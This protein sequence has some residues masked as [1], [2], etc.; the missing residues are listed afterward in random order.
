MPTQV[1]TCKLIAI[2]VCFAFLFVTLFVTQTARAQTAASQEPI[3]SLESFV[4]AGDDVAGRLIDIN[5]T[6]TTIDP[7]WNFGF[8]QDGEHA[9]FV[10]KID[11]KKFTFADR[12]RIQGVAGKGDLKAI[13]KVTEITF[14]EK[15]IAPNPIEVDV[16]NLD[17]GD[18]DASYV[19]TEGTV[20]QVVC[21]MGQTL[22]YC[23]NNGVEFHACLH[24][25]QPMDE[26]WKRV[27]AKIEISGVLGV[28]IEP[29][30]ERSEHAIGKRDIECF[31]IWAMQDFEVLEGGRKDPLPTS[32]DPESSAG[33]FLLGGQITSLLRASFTMTDSEQA[34]LMK[35]KDFHAFGESNI[36]RV[37]GSRTPSSGQQALVVEVLFS[38]PIPNPIKFEAIEQDSDLWSLVRVTGHPEKIRRKNDRVCFDIRSGVKKAI[39]ELQ[40]QATTSVELLRSARLVDVRGIVSEIDEEGVCKVVVSDSNQVL[41][42]EPK[43]SIWKYVAAVLFPLT[44]LI[45]IGFM[46]VKAQRNRADSLAESIN[47]M[48]TR[49]VSTYEAIS[50]GLLAVDV[51][52]RVLT[53]NSEFCR[54]IG[55]NL[56]PGEKFTASTSQDFLGQMKNR[57]AVEK[58]IFGR[59]TDSKKVCRMEIE[60]VRPEPG[61]FDLEVSD[62][63]SDKQARIGRLFLLRDRTKERQLQAELIH[64]NKI[65]AVGQL[66]GGIAHDFN[67]ILTA[68]TANLSLLDLEAEDD[69]RATVVSAAESA[70]NRGTEMVRR[71]LTYSGKTKLRPESQSINSVIRELH[72]FTKATFDSRYEFSF[73]LDVS[74]PLVRVDAGAIEQVILNL[75]LNARDSMPNG[76]KILTV[77]RCDTGA[78]ESVVRIWVVDDGPGVPKHIQ[79][80]IFEPF[81]TTKAGQAGTGLGLSTSKR[82][83][84]ELN[85]TLEYK[86]SSKPG[87]RFVIALPTSTEAQVVEESKEPIPNCALSGSKTI[88]VVDDEDAIRKIY[89]LILEPHEIQV[90]TAVN[91]QAALAIL[92]QEHE[93]IDLVLLD[94]TMPGMSGLDVLEIVSKKYSKIP[95][96]LCSGYLAGI[97]GE[98]DDCVLKLPKPFSAEQLLKIVSRTLQLEQATVENEV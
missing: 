46:W 59:Q 90:L 55:H 27:G 34:H 56:I 18:H 91:G 53:V 10:D 73:D 78:E 69:G 75:Y 5:A 31:R 60:I 17:F 62:I 63:V 38:A 80:S 41:V 65:E 8:V 57:N 24:E 16:S 23:E 32:F 93:R 68:I 33:T 42:V 85:G 15:G 94:L 26:L 64:S 66:V 21:S 37:A 11:A 47:A 52:S 96:I 71:L 39:V 72:Q 36:A 82:L 28:T 44:V 54:L 87:S 70:A 29:G 81:F 67:N 89:S 12:V 9:V 22:Y 3:T 7:V 50:D 13:I 35:V 86:P 40:G 92:K 4:D 84:R 19:K 77:T 61:V 74:D 83:I 76:G 58:L 45:S 30:T 79:D 43:K 2:G 97:A 25:T 14:L 20:L 95:V 51:D 49:L 88:L 6:V 1:S 48:H 98:I